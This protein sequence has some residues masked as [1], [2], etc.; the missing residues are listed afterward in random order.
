MCVTNN[1]SIR[2]AITIITNRQ[3]CI[4][5]ILKLPVYARMMITHWQMEDS[6]QIENSIHTRDIFSKRKNDSRVNINR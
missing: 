2:D 1:D 6:Q 4:N 5:I 3:S